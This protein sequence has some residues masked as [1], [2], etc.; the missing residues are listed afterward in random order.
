MTDMNIE[1]FL[2]ECLRT[3]WFYDYSDDHSVWN[4]GKERDNELRRIAEG[5]PILEKIYS[6]FRYRYTRG[7]I[8]RPQLSDYIEEIN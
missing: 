5:S 6:D 1:Q 3:D 7:E 8:E 4:R 2:T